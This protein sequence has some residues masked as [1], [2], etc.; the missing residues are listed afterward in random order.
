MPVAKRKSVKATVTPE[1]VPQPIAAP[2]SVQPRK[3]PLAFF[4]RFKPS[5]YT[6][7]LMALL[8]IASFFLG[9]LV[10]KVQYLQVGQGYAPSAQQ[11]AGNQPQVPAQ[12][13]NVSLGHFPV[14]GKSDAKVTIIEFADLR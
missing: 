11:A 4:K 7:I 10:D 5:G 13:Q 14:L 2:L 8:L 3:N 12:K 6:P 9:M 1:A